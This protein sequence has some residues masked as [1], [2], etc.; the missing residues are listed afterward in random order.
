MRLGRVWLQNLACHLE[1]W[2]AAGCSGGPRPGSS[3]MLPSER[4]L[5]PLAPVRV[6]V[7]LRCGCIGLRAPH[8]TRLETRTKESDM[9]ASRRVLK[10]GRRK[11]A[12]ER[13]I[14]A[15]RPRSSVKGSSWSM[16]VGTRKMVNYA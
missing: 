13:V 12:D 10:P 14:T 2:T 8:P 1:A 5:I 3:R 4:P 6:L 7:S 15:G 16:P 11:E 9:R